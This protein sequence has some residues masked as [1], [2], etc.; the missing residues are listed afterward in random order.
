M[1]QGSF[2]MKY[3]AQGLLQERNFDSGMDETGLANVHSLNWLMG[4]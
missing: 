1:Y 3:D 2:Q 4:M